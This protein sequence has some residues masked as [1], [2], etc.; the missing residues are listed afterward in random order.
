MGKFVAK[1]KIS[2]K[3]MRKEVK[4]FAPRLKHMKNGDSLTFNYSKRF[5]IEVSKTKQGYFLLPTGFKNGL[6]ITSLRG[7]E[8][9]L[10]L[11]IQC[12]V[13]GLRSVKLG[14]PQEPANVQEDLRKKTCYIT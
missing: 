9:A 10:N 11:L 3:K 13:E 6:L 4:D 8:T 1:K 12:Y 2:R 5:A 7:I 14:K